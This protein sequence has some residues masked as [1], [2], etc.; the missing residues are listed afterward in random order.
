[1]SVIIQGAVAGLFAGF[2]AA[3][4]MD[5]FQYNW[6]DI[7]AWIEKRKA[8]NKA[9]AP[10]PPAPEPAPTPQPAAP[11]PP[12]P[13]WEI[14]GPSTARVANRF[15]FR[16]F[17]G[18]NLQ[19]DEIAA[20]GE[21]VHFGFGMLN[22]LVYGVLVALFPWA[23]FGFG[24]GFATLLFIGV[25]ELLLWII[26]MAKGPWNYALYIH[27]YAYA[28]HVVYGIALESARQVLLANFIR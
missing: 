25:D 10:P 5:R 13:A 26:G 16:P 24:I 2:V 3:Y 23:S 11:A 18:R 9:G 19:G 8:T 14:P 15:F 22:G 17:T 21:I 6:W 4:V 7:A 1:M 12:K 27:V 20:A 28:S